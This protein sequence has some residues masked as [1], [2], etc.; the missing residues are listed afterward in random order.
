MATM[1]GIGDE[2]V[3]AKTGRTWDEWIV[4]LDRVGAA[5]L[6]HARIA[7]LVHERFGVG[8]WWCQMVTVGYEQA[9]GRRAA[10]QTADGWIA[11]AS[12]TIAASADDVF[13]V[14]NDARRRRGWLAEPLTVRKSTAAKSLR[15][16]WP[17]GSNVDVTLVARGAAKTQVAVQHAKLADDAAVATMKAH[18]KDA[19]A[20]LAASLA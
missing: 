9:K 1:A 20:R 3:R 10:H 14:W 8:A 15:I 18:W 11:N 12:L 16:T 6:D 13:A 17:D 5:S 4:A 7:A 19:L 2:A